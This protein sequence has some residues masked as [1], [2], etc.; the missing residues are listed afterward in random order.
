LVIFWNS[1]LACQ[2]S[3]R[4]AVLAAEHE[5]VFLPRLPR[6]N[7]FGSLAGVVSAERLNRSARYRRRC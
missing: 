4:R 5:I 1:F 3:Q 2:R 7:P 6:R